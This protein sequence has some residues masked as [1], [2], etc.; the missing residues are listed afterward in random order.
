MGEPRYLREYAG[1]LSARGAGRFR[2]EYPGGV[3][4]GGGL[5][6]ELADAAKG[7]RT[8]QVEGDTEYIPVQS[9][10][11]RVWRL[12]QCDRPVSARYITVGQSADCDVTVPEYTLSARHCSFTKGRSARIADLGSLNGTKMNGV[13]LPP[14]KL[15]PIESGAKL[16][17]GR[18]LLQYFE[19]DGFLARLQD[20]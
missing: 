10:M 18:L 6:G 12:T 5:V 7:R 2:A 11:D 16:T 4:V 14:R 3:L 19:R 20:L 13:A 15:V 9:L 1:V 8:H 17:M